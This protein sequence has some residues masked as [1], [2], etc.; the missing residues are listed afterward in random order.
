M[1]LSDFHFDLPPELIAKEPLDNRTDSRLLV[2]ERQSQKLSHRFFYHILDY[3]N[4]GDL[5]VFNDTKVLKARL[6]GEKSTGGKV[7]L[8]LERILAPNQ[9]VAH[10][11]ANRSL[12]VG[13]QVLLSPEVSLKVIGRRDN[14]FVLQVDN[15]LSVLD[16]LEQFGHIPLPPYIDRADNSTDIERYQ[17][18]Y[19]K[20][21]GAVAAPTAG[22]HFNDA[23]LAGLKAKGIQSEFI[24]LHV[25]AGTFTPVKTDNI[26][27][28]QMHS[29]WLHVNDKVVET[30]CQTKAAGH[31]VIAVGT[32]V[33]R[34]LETAALKGPLAAFE[35]D[36][37]IF[38]YPGFEFK[39]V[40]G[41]VTN[42]HLP[43]STLLMLVSAFLGQ[44]QA[45][46]IYQQAINERY[47]FF[48]YGDACLFL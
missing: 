6:Y 37:D 44:A 48:S 9:F 4:P 3:F 17:T 30:I 43:E 29:E 2:Y 22:L 38:I 5:L 24:T 27:E 36:S 31:K 11:R 35:G 46:S 45:L 14:L 10:G 39:V 15:E 7:E 23:L 33:V 19:A 34:S 28:H 25:G 13:Q 18:V 47:R 16:C 8:L 40:D 32:T 12:K 1:H 21:E 26:E 20:H 42:F 41:M